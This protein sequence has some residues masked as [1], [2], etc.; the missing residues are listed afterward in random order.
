MKSQS[1]DKLNDFERAEKIYEIAKQ[2]MQG[3]PKT[4]IAASLGLSIDVID[5]AIKEWD[6]YIKHRAESDPDMLDRFLENIIR[7]D[8]EIRLLNEQ[9]WD[10]INQA[11]EN[12][13][14]STKIQALRLA[15]DLMETK[16][17]LFQIMSPRL[18]SGYIE[19]TKR[20]ERVNA[21]LSEIIRNVISGC[22]RCSEMA[23]SQLEDIYRN[24]PELQRGDI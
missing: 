18:E 23:W 7:F 2:Y 16:A 24:Q 8:E 6:E 3:R 22:S 21:I 12:G 19:R 15:K 4:K 5:K 9:T 11:E 10:V 1:L 17:R 13:A 14:M 20:V